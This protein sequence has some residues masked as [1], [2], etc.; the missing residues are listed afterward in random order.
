MLILEVGINHFGSLLEAKKYLNFFLK[1]DFEYLTFQIQTEK[2][3]KKFSSKINFE[4]PVTFY[5][6]AI[7]KVKKKKKNRSGYM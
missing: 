2:F 3:Y 6:E 5:L 4:L 7:K 1:S